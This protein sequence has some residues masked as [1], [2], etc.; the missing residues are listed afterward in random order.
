MDDDELHFPGRPS[1]PDAPRVA[2]GRGLPRLNYWQLD[3]LVASGWPTARHTPLGATAARHR[4]FQKSAMFLGAQTF[5]ASLNP[6][7]VLLC[8]IARGRSPFFVCGC[9]HQSEESLDCRCSL[10][11]QRERDA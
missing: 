10:H 3:R 7:V 6:R 1:Q 2:R 9:G 11:T 4:N 5:P 8:S